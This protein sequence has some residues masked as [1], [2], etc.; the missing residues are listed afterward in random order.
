MY[1][2]IKRSY[3]TA[4]YLILHYILRTIYTN[5]TALPLTTITTSVS[6]LIQLRYHYIYIYIY[7]YIYNNFGVLTA[8]T[9]LL[10]LQEKLCFPS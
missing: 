4:L 6:I 2:T 1:L 8:T 10:F 5:T 7:I 9:T 3:F